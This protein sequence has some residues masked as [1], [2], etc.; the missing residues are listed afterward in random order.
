MIINNSN[1]KDIM[2][3]MESW[4][5]GNAIWHVQE[6]IKNKKNIGFKC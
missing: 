6:K 3:M 1:L 4:R 2:K 5:Q